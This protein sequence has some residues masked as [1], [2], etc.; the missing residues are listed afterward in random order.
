MGELYKLSFPN[1]KLYIGKS[2]TTAKERFAGHRWTAARPDTKNGNTALYHAWR[3]Y[4]APTLTVLAVIENDLLNETEKSAIASY[5]TL[6]PFGYN[7]TLGG[8]G[9]SGW[10]PNQEQRDKSST[11][12][13]ALNANLEFQKR[14]S[15]RGKAS[16]TAQWANPEFQKR[17]SARM[18]ARMTAQMADPVRKK[19]LMAG[20]ERLW[21]EQR[22][23]KAAKM[24]DPEYVKQRKAANAARDAKY[25]AKK[26]AAKAAELK[27]AA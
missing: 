26:K 14:H 12:M 20:L 19:K 18:K 16:M 5:E 27:Q 13:T 7:L 24:A 21:A 4:G 1:G 10:V 25:R 3:K 23:A 8:E 6:A 22:A 9:T 15:A 11:K 2:D 17:R